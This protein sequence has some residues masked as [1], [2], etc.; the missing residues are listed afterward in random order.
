[1]TEKNDLR[2]VFL[3]TNAMEAEEVRCLLEGSGLTPVIFNPRPSRRNPFAPAALAAASVML[4]ADQL[5]RAA[6]VLRDAGRLTGELP[7]TGKDYDGSTD[8]GRT[9]F[10]RFV[11]LV[12]GAAALFLVGAVLKHA[13]FHG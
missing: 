9:R 8:I 6:D 5:E 7:A 13:I 1:M 10:F 2:P 11:L 12:I 3:T 4:P